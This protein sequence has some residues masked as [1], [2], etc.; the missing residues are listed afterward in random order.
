MCHALLEAVTMAK[1]I[2]ERFLDTFFDISAD[3]SGAQQTL[4]QPSA[5]TSVYAGGILV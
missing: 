2:L 5:H 3:H 4:K 1:R